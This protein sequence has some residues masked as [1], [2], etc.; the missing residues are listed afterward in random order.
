MMPGT[1]FLVDFLRH[2]QVSG[3]PS[4]LGVTDRPLSAEGWRSMAVTAEKS[5]RAEAIVTS[6]LG[7]CAAFARFWGEKNHLPVTVDPGW[8]EYNFGQWDGQTTEDLMVK[9]PERLAAF[10]NDPKNHPPPGGESM[11]HFQDRISSSLD[12]LFHSPS[13][14][15]LLVITHG[16]VM[17]QLIA[18]LLR[19]PFQ[20]M[21]PIDIPLCAFLRVV[22]IRMP[23]PH[24][25][26]L[27]FLGLV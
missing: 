7:R 26:K 15:H 6:P 24:P 3:V 22:M 9:N 21:W 5:S 18:M 25:R 20:D 16:G 10:W 13:G 11:E 8:S 19:R 1:P 14:A 23:P 27:S 2:G 12:A 4:L 17:R